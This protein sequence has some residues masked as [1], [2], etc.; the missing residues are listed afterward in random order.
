VKWDSSRPVPWKRLALEW[1]I[2]TLLIIAAMFTFT[3]ERDPAAYAGLLLGGTVYVVVG[4][5]LAKLGYQ[6]VRLSQPVLRSGAPAAGAGG[7]TQTRQRP[8]PAPTRR[9]STGPGRKAQRKRR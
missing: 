9:T 1:S 6:R 4:Y 8:K 3:D 7:A 2:V 5:V